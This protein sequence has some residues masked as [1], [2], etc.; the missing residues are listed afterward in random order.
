VPHFFRRAPPSSIHDATTVYDLAVQMKQEVIALR[1][2]GQPE[3]FT[4]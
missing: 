3:I 2:P 1:R 4:R